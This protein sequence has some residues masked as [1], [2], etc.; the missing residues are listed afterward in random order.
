MA[1]LAGWA[2]KNKRA[3]AVRDAAGVTKLAGCQARVAQTSTSSSKQ[4]PCKFQSG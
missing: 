1:I 4:N 2:A 3:T